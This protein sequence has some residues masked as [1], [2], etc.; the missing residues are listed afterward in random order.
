MIQLFFLFR[1]RGDDVDPLAAELGERLPA[2][3]VVLLRAAMEVPEPFKFFR[4]ANIKANGV[5]LAILQFRPV[6]R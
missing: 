6:S 2:H 3:Q 4:D 5:R 1:L